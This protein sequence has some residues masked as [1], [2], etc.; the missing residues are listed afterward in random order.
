MHQVER[1]LNIWIGAAEKYL[2][3]SGVDALLARRAVR[4]SAVELSGAQWSSVELV[5][6]AP[7][8]SL[9]TSWDCWSI[10]GAGSWRSR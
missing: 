9:I 1:E 6:P 10:I 4:T 8:L 5:V 2:S 7:D 3:I